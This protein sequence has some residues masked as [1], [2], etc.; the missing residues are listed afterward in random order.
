MDNTE[1]QRIWKSYDQKIDDMLAINKELAIDLTRRKLSGEI[2]KLYRPKWTAIFIGVP[3][4]FV[5]IAITVIAS[6]AKAYLVAIGFGVIALIMTLVLIS[7][8][9]QLCLISR[10]KNNE[11]VLTTQ[12]QLSKLRIASF[13]SLNLAVFQLPFWSVCWMSIEALRESPL[14]YGGINL[15]IF[16]LLTYL[17]Y[18]TYQK[19][20]YK[21]K[22]SKVRDFFMSG[23]EWD[24]I[25]KSAELLEQI[26]G[27]EK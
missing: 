24:P 11:A 22:D 12:H 4:T 9:Y 5:L 8:F 17:A 13:Q 16:L 18:W 26:K 21:T 23:R 3:Y 6:L 15:S 7:Y 2:R 10:I 14:I 20:S 19:L 25:L 1:L 27:Y